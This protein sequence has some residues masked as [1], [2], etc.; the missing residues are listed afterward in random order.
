MTSASQQAFAAR[1]LIFFLFNEY[2]RKNGNTCTDDIFNVSS[3]LTLSLNQ[4]LF[5]SNNFTSSS[6]VSNLTETINSNEIYYPTKS[7]NYTIKTNRK[8]HK[9]VKFKLKSRNDQTVLSTMRTLLTSLDTSTLINTNKSTI[10]TNSNVFL[11]DT[12]ISNETYYYFNNN[13][14]YQDYIEYKPNLFINLL[15]NFGVYFLGLLFVII[16]LLAFT[17][18]MIGINYQ[19]IK[20]NKK[21]LHKKSTQLMRSKKNM[22][23][24]I[25]DNGYRLNRNSTKIMNRTDSV[26]SNIK[27]DAPNL[28]NFHS[29]NQTY[30]RIEDE[31]NE[32][33]Y[34]LPYMESSAKIKNA[35]KDFKFQTFTAKKFE[36][37]KNDLLESDI[38]KSEHPVMEY[39]V[40]NSNRL[41]SFAHTD[42][43]RKSFNE[44]CSIT[45]YST[46]NRNNKQNLNDSDKT[47]DDEDESDYEEKKNLSILSSSSFQQALVAKCTETSFNP[48]SMAIT[49]S[50]K[51]NNKEFRL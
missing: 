32:N 16:L 44:K 36:H 37:F 51:P 41:I 11:N 13:E 39:G 28:N 5:E 23:F 50:S 34:E 25:I 27:N 33:I 29:L 30:E 22:S 20:Q 48:K 8:N 2:L 21:F 15:N 38:S 4:S 12:V 10:F 43:Y 45:N 9:K 1:F 19:L 3:N 7:F 49:T 26:V 18:V 14:F 31:S 24:D 46:F 40:I 17:L 35:S 42:E 47:E 6:N